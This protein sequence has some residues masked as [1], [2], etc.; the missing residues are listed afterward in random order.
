MIKGAVVDLLEPL[1]QAD[2]Q[3]LMTLVKRA[4]TDDFYAARNGNAGNVR[5]L[6]NVFAYSRNSARDNGGLAASLVGEQDISPNKEIG[7]ALGPEPIVVYI[8]KE[9]CEAF[10]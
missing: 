4:R 1:R 9:F 6:K 8:R 10:A 5:I 2:R 3:Q 7:I